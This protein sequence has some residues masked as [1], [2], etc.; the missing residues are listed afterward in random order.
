MVF[1]RYSDYYKESKKNKE[2]TKRRGSH[3]GVAT[4]RKVTLPTQYRTL[5]HKCSQCTRKD[6]KK[7]HL[8]G[9]EVR[10]LCPVC[11]IKNKYRDIKE[12]PNFL[13]ASRLQV[14]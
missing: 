1:L 5:N 8:T 14:K 10:W 11:V 9:K 2:V 3:G 6:A 7:Y 13:K 12:I 4:G